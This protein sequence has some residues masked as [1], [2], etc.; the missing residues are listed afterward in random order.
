MFIREV[1]HAIDSL[2]L[3]D[4]DRRKVYFRNAIRMP[5]AGPA[6]GAGGRTSA[7]KTRRLART[8]R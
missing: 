2:K 5:A 6:G 4:T 8:K 3:K 7:A 1:I